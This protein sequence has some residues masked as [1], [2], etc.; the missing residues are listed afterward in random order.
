VPGLVFFLALDQNRAHGTS[1]M[2]A[3]MLSCAGVV[4]YSAHGYVDWT[5]AAEMAVGGVFGACLGAKFAAA[6]KGRILRRIFSVFVFLVGTRMIFC[7]VG[8]GDVEPGACAFGPTAGIEGALPVLG[9]GAVTGFLSA[10]LGIGGGMVMIP[11]MALLLGVGQKTAQGVSLAVMM[12]TALTGMLLHRKMGNVSYRIGG[13]TGLGTVVGSVIGATIAAGLNTSSL[14][15]AF[16]AFLCL[17]ALLMAMKK[18]SRRD[19]D[20]EVC[21]RS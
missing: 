21:G 11:A 20:V 9:I 10:L 5:L 16:G 18:D 12:P 8:I 1:L 4:T 13:L 17:M 19:S 3:L 7:G 15:L 2:S 14:R 6:V